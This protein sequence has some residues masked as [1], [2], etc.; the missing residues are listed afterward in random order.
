MAWLKISTMAKAA[1]WALTLG[2][3][4][5]GHHLYEINPSRMHHHV[6]ETILIM[7]LVITFP[8]GLF[9]SL[10]IAAAFAVLSFATG[11]E[12]PGGMTTM[13]LTGAVVSAGGYYQWFVL[14]PRFLG[15]Q[16]AAGEQPDA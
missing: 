6:D 10:A 13:A 1:W 11:V 14:V 4:A 2:I 9:V 5:W 8:A 3:L 7:L 15:R 12:V 16:G